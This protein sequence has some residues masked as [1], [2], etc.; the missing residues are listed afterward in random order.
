VV[1]KDTRRSRRTAGNGSPSTGEPVPY[2]SRRREALKS[3]TYGSKPVRPGRRPVENGDG[4]KPYPHLADVGP[5]PPHS[6]GNCE[7]SER[8]YKDFAAAAERG[9][10]WE[11]LRD[12]PREARERNGSG[13]RSQTGIMSHHTFFIRYLLDTATTL[14][15]EYVLFTI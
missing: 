9:T 11:R 2:P 15:K 1:P 4:F 3:K 7:H 12:W 8:G 14:P 6:A 13:R 10:Y 5:T